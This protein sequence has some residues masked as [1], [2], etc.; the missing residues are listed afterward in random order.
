MPMTMLAARAS[1]P[2]LTALTYLR[3]SELTIPTVLESG[4]G[5][6]NIR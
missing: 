5:L 4:L 3:T 6:R 2:S 1:W